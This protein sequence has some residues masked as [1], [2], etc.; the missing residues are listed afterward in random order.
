MHAVRLRSE[1]TTLKSKLRTQSQGRDGVHHQ[2]PCGFRIVG[3]D[4]VGYDS[5]VCDHVVCDPVARGGAPTCG[6][7]A[8]GRDVCV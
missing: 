7:V 8:A 6:E 3:C 1:Q 4:G 5:V 2:R